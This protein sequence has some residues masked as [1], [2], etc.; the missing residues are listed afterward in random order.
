MPV[1]RSCSLAVVALMCLAVVTAPLAAALPSDQIRPQ[2]ARVSG[3]LARGVARSPTL[4]AL[5]ERIERGDVIV[6]LEE[7]RTLG[8]GLAASIA[9]MSA[10][11]HV[12]YLRAAV[13]SDLS[14]R[15]GL[16]MIAHELQHVVEV[17]DDPTVR[18]E[19]ALR[20]LYQRIGHPTGWNGRQWDTQAAL[21]TGETVRLEV[22]G[23]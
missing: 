16:A 5:V 6:Y 1:L 22:A 18:S 10:T 14:E 7:R 11:P 19:D 20:A 23:A 17:I 2:S 8:S 3:W 15:E 13:R 4:R 12:R 9:W 21:R